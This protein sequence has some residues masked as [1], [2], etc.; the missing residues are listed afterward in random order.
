MVVIILFSLVA[1][2]SRKKPFFTKNPSEL[3][4]ETVRTNLV[5]S[6]RGLGF[7]I[8]GGNEP[9]QDFLQI[10]NVVENGP[11]YLDGRLKTGTVY[12]LKTF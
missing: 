7:T 3:N 2:E 6:S 4:G 5:K 12:R 9:D 11:A 8:V 10:K 1:Y